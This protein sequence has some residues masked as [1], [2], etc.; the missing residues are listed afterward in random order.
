MDDLIKRINELTA[1]AKERELSQSET[2]ERQKL[3]EEYLEIFRSNFK[4]QLKSVKIVD[5]NGN[6]VTPDKLKKIKDR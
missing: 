6:D 4:E 3:R 5:E 2:I 1:L